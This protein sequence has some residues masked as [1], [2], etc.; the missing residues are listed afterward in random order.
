MLVFHA[1]LAAFFRTSAVIASN[2]LV[3][4]IAIAT[5]STMITTRRSAST[6]V[7]VDLT[8]SAII[9]AHLLIFTLLVIKNS[10]QNL[11]EVFLSG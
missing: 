1:V 4:T 3:L 9:E 6:L 7:T 8:I 2:I 10:C 5:V 11:N